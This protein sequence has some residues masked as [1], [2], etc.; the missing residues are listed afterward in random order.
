MINFRS[1]S[2]KGAFNF[3]R[4]RVLWSGGL[5]RVF[6]VDGMVLETS[7]EEPL[8]KVGLLRAWSVSTV[9]GDITMRGKCITCG[10]KKWWRVTYA[11]DNELWN[12]A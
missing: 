7:A 9:R 5:L 1:V 4:A 10:G 8:K 3:G 12:T 2:I 11:P 6:T